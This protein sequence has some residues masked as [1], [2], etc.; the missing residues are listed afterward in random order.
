MHGF[1]NQELN[2]NTYFAKPFVSWKRGDNQKLNNLPR[3]YIP[4]KRGMSYKRDEEIRIIQNG[5]NNKPRKRKGVQ[6]SRRADPS[7][8]Q[9]RC[10]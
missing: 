8:T 5:L 2:K 7:T 9:V 4:K 6:K 3:Q 1:V 10:I